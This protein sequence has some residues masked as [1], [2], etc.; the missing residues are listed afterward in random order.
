MKKWVSGQVVVLALSI[1][2]L[3]QVIYLVRLSTLENLAPPSEEILFSQ[4]VI[5]QPKQAN[6]SLKKTIEENIPRQQPFQSSKNALAAFQ[7]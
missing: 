3:G 6:D 4:P 2:V 7:E 5:N 1:W